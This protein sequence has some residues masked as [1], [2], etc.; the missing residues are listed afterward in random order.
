[1]TKLRDDPLNTQY[2]NERFRFLN[3]IMYYFCSIEEF[4]QEQV[5]EKI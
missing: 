5:I 2:S 3:K 1:M 4:C